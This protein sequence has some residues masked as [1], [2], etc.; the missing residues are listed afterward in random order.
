MAELI[1]TCPE[2]GLRDEL[3]HGHLKVND[4]Q[5][6]CSYHLHPAKCP[7]LRVPLIAARR[8]LEFLDWDGISDSDE[9]IRILPSLIEAPI[10]PDMP[11]MSHPAARPVAEGAD[12]DVEAVGAA[13][14]QGA[15]VT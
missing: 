12:T 5:G 9:E 7:R 8:M 15:R 11:S 3:A 1:V 14:G 13:E 2:C 4:P 6:Q 10:V